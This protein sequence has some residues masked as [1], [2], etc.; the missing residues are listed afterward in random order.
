MNFWNNVSIAVSKIMSS[1]LM[2]SPDICLFQGINELTRKFLHLPVLAPRRDVVKYWKLDKS[3]SFQK[4]DCKCFQFSFIKIGITVNR[5]PEFRFFFHPRLCKTEQVLPLK[6]YKHFEV[7]VYL[8]LC[9]ETKGKKRLNEL[10]DAL[11]QLSF[12]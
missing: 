9:S 10:F 8:Y 12:F 6:T 11:V 5:S 2:L 4:L 1:A 7:Q 3:C